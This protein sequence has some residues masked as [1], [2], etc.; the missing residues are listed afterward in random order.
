MEW[1]DI[2]SYAYLAPM[3][4]KVFFNFDSALANLIGAFIIFGSGFIS[5][6]FGSIVFGRI[7]DL[8]GRRKAFIYSLFGVTGCTLC[9]GCLPT[10]ATA[11]IYAPIC[12]GLLRI[13]Q[14]IPASGEVPGA[15][16]FLYENSQVENRRFIT[17]WTGVGNQ[18]GAILGIAQSFLMDQ[19]MSEDFLTSWGWRI[20]F[21][22]GGFLGFFGIYLR[23]QL[24]E[25]PVFKALKEH[26]RVDK[27]T[28]STVIMNC[29][30]KLG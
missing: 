22:S 11:G 3:I 8:L 28:F 18:I 19:F 9:M 23:S 6:P 17:S 12:L 1:F 14:S 26:H 24:Y 13:L 25:T 30:K 15:I 2:Y 20:V 29:K 27:Q 5:R 4:A 21:W 7:G 16:C 10:Y